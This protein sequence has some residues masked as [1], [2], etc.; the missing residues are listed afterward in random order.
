M[1]HSG[2]LFCWLV[3]TNC[4][5]MQIYENNIIGEFIWFGV[6]FLFYSGLNLNN[7]SV[8]LPAWR[9][10]LRAHCCLELMQIQ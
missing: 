9:N 2:S 4:K 3:K 7:Y 5:L 1:F 8:D 10:G 6:I